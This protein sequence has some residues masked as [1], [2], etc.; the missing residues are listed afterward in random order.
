VQKSVVRVKDHHGTTWGTGFFIS[1]TGHLLTCAHVL[2]DAGGWKNVRVCDLPVTCLY[3]GDPDR[4]DFCLLQVEDYMPPVF[5]EL[6]TDFDDRDEFL[7]FGFSNDDFYGA[8]IHGKITAFARCGKLG[9]QKL[10]RLETFS[11]AQRIEGGQS[12]APVFVYKKG[13]WSAIGLIAASEDLQGGLAIPS[14]S[15]QSK[16]AKIITANNKK[17]IAVYAAVGLAIVGAVASIPLLQSLFLDPCQ[18]SQ[19][20]QE[21]A[22]IA[23]SFR[24][25]TSDFKE[26]E[27]NARKLTQKCAYKGYYFEAKALTRQKNFTQ[28]IKAFDESLK[29]RESPEARFGLGAS[30]GFDHQYLKAIDT[31]TLL[32][33]KQAFSK[34][35]DPTSNLNERN[36]KF[37]IAVAHH[38]LISKNFKGSEFSETEQKQHLKEALSR[39]QEI[40][41]QTM[42]N[43]CDDNAVGGCI[44]PYRAWSADGLAQVYALMYGLNPRDRVSLKQAIEYLEEG[45][46]AKPQ[47]E[48]QNALNLLEAPNPTEFFQRDTAYLR[49]QPEFKQLLQQWRQKLRS[50]K[51]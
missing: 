5:T 11:D 34:E 26:T 28:A 9:D 2:E 6:G 24:N 22:T 40:F 31:L 33:Q 48:R 16:L 23:E 42:A 43:S 46:Q 51:Q 20:T 35:F 44:D 19:V 50:I 39:Y 49:T 27:A 37:N 38:R 1:K 14:N 29:H 17:P 36:L 25:E 12:G 10:I 3:A 7:S 41:K 45:F 8:P 47:E 30:Y 32:E 13:K 4:D 15:I 21:V 18:S